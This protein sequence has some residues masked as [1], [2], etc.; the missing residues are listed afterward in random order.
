MHLRKGEINLWV[1][2]LGRAA[3]FYLEAFGFKRIAGDESY[4]KLSQGDITLTLFQARTKEH[5]A[6]E[7]GTQSMMTADLLTD[8]FDAAVAGITK[9]GGDVAETGTWEGKRHTIFRDLDGISWELI[10]A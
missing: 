4:L 6:P 9:A 2:D 10:E 7:M 1:S 5:Y 8:D 3:D